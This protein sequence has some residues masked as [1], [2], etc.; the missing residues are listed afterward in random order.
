MGFFFQ[1]IQKAVGAEPAEQE[2]QAT[3][4]AVA[5]AGNGAVAAVPARVASPAVPAPA[6]P[7]AEQTVAVVNDNP[8]VRTTRR[9]YQLPQTLERLVSV[10]AMPLVGGNIQAIEQSRV[11]RTRMVQLMKT[12]KLRSIMIT[13]AMPSEGKSLTSCNLAFSMS[14]LQGKKVLL[15][16]ADLRKPT[17]SENLQIK[18]KK[19][20]N[21][22]LAGRA[23]LDE[24]CL[25]P[26][27][28]ITV[29]PTLP[30]IDSN[31]A[32]LLHGDRMIGLMKWAVENYDYVIV[33]SPPLFPIADAQAL[34]P[35][36]D[37]AVLVVRADRTPYDLVT[38]AANVLEGKLVGTLLNGAKRMA[39]NRYYS[40]YLG[41][42]G[43]YGYGAGAA[44]KQQQQG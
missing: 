19:G 43:R 31:S 42:Y 23:T 12:R 40:S 4:V 41:R 33:D 14:Q 9:P 8:F 44:E 7:A 3:P 17:V 10:A 24:V 13:S 1:A 22:F 20:L 35:L 32:E 27:P 34:S 18:V 28:S 29:L 30:E 37:G 11:I 38:Q 36:V 25:D 5:P 21:T 6:A 2:Q 15:L 26:S 39:H 16:D